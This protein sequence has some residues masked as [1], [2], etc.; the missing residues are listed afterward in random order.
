MPCKR[1]FSRHCERGKKTRQTEEEVGRQHQRMDRPGVWQVPEGSGEQGK[2]EKTGRKIMCGAPTTLCIISSSCSLHP[3]EFPPLGH[4]LWV[5][6]WHI[7]LSNG[8]VVPFQQNIPPEVTFVSSFSRDSDSLT[9]CSVTRSNCFVVTTVSIRFHRAVCYVVCIQ[10][11]VFPKAHFVTVVA[12]GCSC[13]ICIVCALTRMIV[14]CRSVGIL[15]IG[16]VVLFSDKILQWGDT[17]CESD[18]AGSRYLFAV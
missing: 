14:L 2:M 4:V 17:L 13:A 15:F 10:E 16:C 1:Q 9:L 18:I 5:W 8:Y 11:N 3:A 6:N 12:L 7:V